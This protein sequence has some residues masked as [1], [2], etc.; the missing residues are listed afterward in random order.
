[1]NATTILPAK[2]RQNGNTHNKR[3]QNLNRG[4]V[5]PTST[6]EFKQ[7]LIPKINPK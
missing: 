7:I 1:M 3:H 4:A 2:R 5:T 6:K